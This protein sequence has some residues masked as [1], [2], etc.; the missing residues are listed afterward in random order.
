MDVHSILNGVEPELVGL[1]VDDA[2]LDPPSGHP[3]SVAMGMMVPAKLIGFERSLHHRSA[4]ELPA[5]Q[6]QGLFEQAALLQILNQS[7][8]GL[9]GLSATLL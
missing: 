8:G 7:H 2:W 1:A 5:P 6:H 9:V 4:A 3:D